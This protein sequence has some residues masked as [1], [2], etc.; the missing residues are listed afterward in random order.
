[1]RYTKRAL[2]QRQGHGRIR[3]HVV[4]YVRIAGDVSAADFDAA[5]EGLVVT[6]IMR[7]PKEV[8]DD[9]GGRVRRGWRL[10]PPKPHSLRG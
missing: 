5:F 7:A 10:S 9:L 2:R 4:G 6:G 3:H 1:M 8:V